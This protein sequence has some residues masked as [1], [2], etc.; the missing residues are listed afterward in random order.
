MQR[1]ILRPGGHLRLE[2]S[3]GSGSLRLRHWQVVEVMG[4]LCRPP[5]GP[6]GAAAG[7]AVVTVDAPEI[8]DR[9]RQTKCVRSAGWRATCS[10][11]CSALRACGCTMHP[12]QCVCVSRRPAAALWCRGTRPRCGRM[13]GAWGAGVARCS[14]PHPRLAALGAQTHACLLPCRCGSG[15]RPAAS[16]LPAGPSSFLG[17]G[18]PW[19]DGALTAFC[20]GAAAA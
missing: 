8:A 4:V 6:P 12:Y 7:S 11:R 5:R 10:A 17:P 15:R 13:G 2:P 19:L 20:G 18:L 1:V 16:R 3:P 14:A 9:R